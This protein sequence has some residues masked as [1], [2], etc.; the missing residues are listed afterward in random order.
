M[1]SGPWCPGL[2]PGRGRGGHRP[3]PRHGPGRHGPLQRCGRGRQGRRA[4][5][6]PPFSI[7]ATLYGVFSRGLLTGSKPTE[8]GDWRA[9]QP[10]F[11]GENGAKNEDSVNALQRFAHERGMTP[12]QVALAWVL[13]REPAF[14][15]VVKI[16]GD[17]YDPAQMKHLDSERR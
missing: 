15:S 1:V 9:H 10:R 7:S 12:G 16:S 11:A 17:R 13:A 4:R 5:H 14:E 6:G 2:R 8:A 3:R